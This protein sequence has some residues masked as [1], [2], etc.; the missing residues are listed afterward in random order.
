[1]FLALI[2]NQL[3]SFAYLSW[4]FI[5]VYIYR[6]LFILSLKGAITC[7]LLVGL[8]VAFMHYKPTDNLVKALKFSPTGKYKDYFNKQI[9]ET[10]LNPD[11][12]AVRY[13]YCDSSIALTAFNTVMIDQMVWKGFDEDPICIEAQNVI[14]IHIQP[15][16]PAHS[17]ELHKKIN[18]ALTPEAQRFIFKH[19]LGHVSDYHSW[20]TIALNGVIGF[21]AMYSGFSVVQVFIGAYEGLFVLGAAI[22]TAG[23]VDFSLG[24]LRNAFFKAPKEKEADLFAAKYS[25]KKEIEA[26]ADFFEKY[27]ACSQ[28]YRKAVGDNYSEFSPRFFRGY[29]S[30]QER[31]RYLREAAAS[32]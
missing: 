10:G 4:P 1:M 7:S 28:V 30:G 9:K 5:I 16:L 24:C 22:S 12:I 26:A 19:E 11:D 15:I 23:I 27:E 31:V 8:R 25:S 29:V 32:K 14:K 18:D 20:K 13:A 3:Y 6:P 21:A 2:I 17:K